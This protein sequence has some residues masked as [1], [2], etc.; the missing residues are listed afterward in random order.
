MK[1]K[2]REREKKERGGAKNEAAMRRRRRTC[3]VVIFIF[4]S[5]QV[6]WHLHV[7]RCRQNFFSS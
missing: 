2:E 3:K 1:V 4:I 7:L 6:L 5:H